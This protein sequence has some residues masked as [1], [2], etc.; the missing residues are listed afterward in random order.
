MQTIKARILL[1]VSIALALLLGCL[2]TLSGFATGTSVPDQTL[3][4]EKEGQVAT[5]PEK[6]LT[7][8]ITPTPHGTNAIVLPIIQQDASLQTSEEQSPPPTITPTPVPPQSPQV[9]APIVFGAVVIV[10]I[11]LSA[12]ILFDRQKITRGN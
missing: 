3:Y 10:L 1:L 8:T 11:I 2:N 9:N 6:Y 7:Y 5:T 12:W 4:L